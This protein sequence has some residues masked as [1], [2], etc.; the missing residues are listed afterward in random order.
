MLRRRGIA[1]DP[2]DHFL[3]PFLQGVLLERELTTSS[4]FAGFVLR[5]FARGDVVVPA[6][7]MGALPSA[8]AARLPGGTIEYGVRVDAVRPGEV[9]GDGGTRRAQAVVVATDPTTAPGCWESGR[10]RCTA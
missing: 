9:D 6:T 3:R 1:G 2:T 4:R 8:L 5:T 7:G 10:R